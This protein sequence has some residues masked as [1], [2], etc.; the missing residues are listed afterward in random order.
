VEPA[1]ALVAELAGAVLD[2]T[3]VDWA[4][5][6]SRADEDD[7]SLIEQLRVVAVVADVHRGAQLIAPSLN[8]NDFLPTADIPA[9]ETDDRDVK[10]FSGDTV[11]AY[12]LIERLGRGGMGE[13][14]LGERVD[15]RFEQKVAVKLLKRGMDSGE[16]LRRFARERR[17]LARLEHP[18][19]ARLLDG[20]ETA[21]GRPYFVMER[22]EG[23]KIT[24]HCRARGLTL[25]E[26]LSLMAACCDAVDA[27]HRSLVV[28]RDLKPSNILVTSGG[29][30]KLLDFGIA[31]LLGPEDADTQVTGEHGRVLTAAYAA[32]EQII[33]GPVTVA[34]DVF[35]LG[36]V[37]YELLTGALPFDRRAGTA[38]ELAAR[39]EHET[40][41]RPSSKAQQTAVPMGTRITRERWGRRLVGDLDTITMKALARDP[42]RRYASA[43]ALAADLR[44]YLT[45]RPV[46][47]RPDSSGYRLRKFVGRHRVGVAASAIVAVTVL[48]ALAVSLTMT[49]D[50]RREAERAAAA[51]AF[52]TSLFEQIDPDRYVGSAP[53][54]RDILEHGSARLDR[55]LAR[56]PEL[57]ADMQA[58]LGQVF[59]QLSLSAQGEANW[60]RA[61]ATR[62]TLFGPND[63]RTVK[64]KKGLAISLARQARY[65]E[66]EPLFE[67]LVA[68]EESLGDRRELG[69]V[70]VNF[71]NSK[72]LSG[73]YAG[74]E[75]LLQRSLT[76]LEGLGDPMSRSL[77]AALT[78]LGLAYWRDGRPQDAAQLLERALAIHMKLQGPQSSMVAYRKK[79]LSH[80][81]R[82]LG[83]LDKAERY[84]RE[85]LGVAEKLFPPH[86]PF[87]AMA[88]LSLGETAQK[89]GDRDTA[90]QFYERSIKSYEEAPPGDTGLAAS[91]SALA[92]LLQGQGEGTDAV[93][94]YERALSVRRKALGDRHR[95]VAE[96]WGDLGRARAAIGNVSGALDA[97]RASVETFRRTVP[98]DNP[99][100]AGGLFML[101]NVLRLHGRA[102][103]ALPY[104]EEA[105]TIWQKTPPLN[106]RDLTDLDTALA[107]T[108]ASVRNARVVSA[109]R[110]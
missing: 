14:Y 60:R 12:H 93:A 81:Y 66:A 34:T 99:Q 17:I 5:V 16:M 45:S 59:D 3:S 13:V 19:I 68:Q 56:Q 109:R 76:L 44:R 49:A 97:L 43:A 11:G 15:G 54:V 33:G 105:H 98:A 57:R 30:V 46:E 107:A 84:A 24:D 65:A 27:A 70:L 102:M 7:R 92:A 9:P 79:D 80:V 77:A 48:V 32:P 39:V 83:E 100:L 35:A 69:S 6:A 23:E 61:V 2:W 55:D 63:R 62:Q 104:L 82:E 85:A 67:Q 96:S 25:E 87:I 40:A 86:H 50:A 64:A 90:R 89:R 26:R 4:A 91:L 41:E 53:T 103:E 18:G 42:A 58:L 31:K 47:A 78:N 71:G 22:V 38:H 101:G 21:E 88:L 110:N 73:D 8:L 10:D 28:H 94:L 37:L 1:D 74:G 72:R 52:L 108:R 29:F 20:G 36:V 51:Q 95:D 75:A 106:A